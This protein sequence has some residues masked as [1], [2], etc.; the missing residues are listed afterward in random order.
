MNITQELR[1]LKDH[2]SINIPDEY[3]K[4]INET[5]FFDYTDTLLKSNELEIE[6]NHFLKVDKDNPSR[7]LLSWYSFAKSSRADYLTI[8]MGYGNEEI[9]I[10]VIG[11]DTGGIYYIDQI[12]DVIIKKLFNSFSDFKAQLKKQK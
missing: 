12:E 3:E 6:L 10:K 9:A 4:F 11:K 8:A 5:E 1:Y 2:Y 7:D